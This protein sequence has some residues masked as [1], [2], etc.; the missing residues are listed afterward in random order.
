MTPNQ[1]KTKFPHASESFLRRNAAAERM[2]V[3]PSSSANTHCVSERSAVAPPDISIATASDDE[4]KLNKLERA[5][6]SEMRQQGHQFIGIQNVTLKLGHDCRYTPDFTAIDS[7]NRRC[8]YEVKGFMRDDAQVKL[9]VATRLF[10][11]IFHFF[12][13][14]RE[15]GVWQIEAVKP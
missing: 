15:R 9:K 5:W 6:L 11:H 14:K 3:S 12:L 8:A 1:L 7:E 2:E 13:V 10:A 4:S